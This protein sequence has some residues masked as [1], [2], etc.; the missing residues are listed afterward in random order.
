MLG[1]Y[2]TTG[3]LPEINTNKITTLYFLLRTDVFVTYPTPP[4]ALKKS[5]QEHF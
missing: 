2:I 4:A 5:F 3:K 1:I